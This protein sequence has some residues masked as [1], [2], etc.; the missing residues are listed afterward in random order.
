MKNKTHTI[1]CPH[2]KDMVA[3]V[4]KH[5][6]DEFMRAVGLHKEQEQPVQEQQQTVSQPQKPATP[7]A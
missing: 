2:T 3:H 7:K 6:H 4:E 1:Y 5:V